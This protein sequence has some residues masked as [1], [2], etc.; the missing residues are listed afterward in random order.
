MVQRLDLMLGDLVRFHRRHAKLSRMDLARLA[1]V[2]KTLVY[3]LEKGKK[4][5]RMDSVFQVLGVLN[6][7][8]DWHSPL[9]NRYLKGGDEK[10]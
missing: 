5:I 10:S 2:G 8:V 7:A 3:D 1:G 9:K 4:T 6:I